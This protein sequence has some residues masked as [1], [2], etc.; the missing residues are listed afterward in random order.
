MYPGGESW[1][2]AHIPALLYIYIYTS[3][4]KASRRASSRGLGWRLLS[5]LVPAGAD[6][7]RQ[8]SRS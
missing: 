4:K 1:E 6:L 2:E 7:L 8:G 5:R 3:I